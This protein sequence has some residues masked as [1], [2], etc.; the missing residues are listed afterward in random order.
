M[1]LVHELADGVRTAL[2]KMKAATAALKT[3]GHWSGP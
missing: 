2:A 3:A 1:G